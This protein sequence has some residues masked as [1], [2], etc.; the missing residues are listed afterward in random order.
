MSNSN[1]ANQ[2][3]LLISNMISH[4][5]SAVCVPPA[6][7]LIQPHKSARHALPTAHHVFIVPLPRQC[8]A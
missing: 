4:Q 2:A 5:A 1:A 3:A 7:L 8:S 6:K